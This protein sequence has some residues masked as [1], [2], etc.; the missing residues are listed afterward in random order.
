MVK[1][2][3]HIR[4]DQIERHGEPCIDK[5]D[6]GTLDLL[7]TMCREAEWQKNWLFNINSTWREGSTGMHPEGKAVDG[8]FY[9]KMPGDVSVWEQ[10]EFARKYP[11]GGIGAYPFWIT[12]GIHCDSRPTINRIATWWRDAS[13]NDH[14]LAEAKQ[15]FGVEV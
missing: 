9:K 8:Y 12:P 5:M 10:Y 15:I 3:P 11:W 13:E 4:L 7:N 14:S 2:W 6:R 1:L